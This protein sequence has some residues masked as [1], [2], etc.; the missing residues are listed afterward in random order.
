MLQKC[1]RKI[2]VSGRRKNSLSEQGSKA[3]SSVQR[4]KGI[5]KM[6][7]RM[8]QSHDSGS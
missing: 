5:K 6:T 4:V 3:D 1:Q 2:F 8:R 7:L